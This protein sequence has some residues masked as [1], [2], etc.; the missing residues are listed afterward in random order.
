[1]G[2]KELQNWLLSNDTFKEQLKLVIIDSVANQFC[3]LIREKEDFHHNWNYLLLCASLLAKSETEVGQDAALRIAQHCLQSRHI[4]EHLKDGAIIILDS[5]ANKQAIKLAED[6]SLIKEGIFDRLPPVLKKDWVRHDLENSI[7]LSDQTI[8]YTNR[9][10]KLFWDS[11]LSFKW[12]S[13]SAPTSAGKSFIILQWIIEYLR[14]NSNANIV[15]LVPT[16]ALIQQVEHDFKTL[17]KYNNLSKVSVSTLPVLHSVEN[18]AKI[19]IFTQ[20][21]LH[22]F[23]NSVQHK[24]SVDL[25][26][27]DEAHKV[28]DNHR[29]IL[30]QQAIETVSQYNKEI[31]IL[32]ASPLTNNPHLLLEDAPK[33][34]KKTSLVSED[35]MVNQ[36]LIWV[37]QAKGNPK[38]W[39]VELCLPDAITPIGRFEMDYSPTPESK[40]LPFVAYSLASPEG[41]NLIYANL[42]SDAEKIASQLYDLV[43][44]EPEIKNDDL[45]NLIELTKKVIHKDYLLVRVLQK[46]IGF[47]YGNIP[48]LVRTEIEKLFSKNVIKF[49]VCTSTLVEGVN[50]PCRNI[51]IRGPQKGR[52]NPMN[53]SD[54]WNLA[55]RAGRWGKEFQGNVICIDAR[56]RGVWQPAAPIKRQ[57]YNIQRTCD[58]ILYH[59]VK[60]LINFI[61]RKL[62]LIDSEKLRNLEYVF[63]YLAHSYIQHGNLEETMWA[64]RFP[65]EVVEQLETE[66]S[67]SLNLMKIPNEI[68]LRNPGINPLSINDLLLYFETRPKPLDEL[69][70][71][72]AESDNAIDVYLLI[73]QRLNKHLT[74]AFGNGG[75]VYMLAMLIVNW[76]RGY[77]L[78]RLIASRIKYLENKGRVYRIP[79]VIRDT[80]NDVEQI[81]RFEAPKYLSCYIDVLQYYLKSNNKGDLEESLKNISLKLELGVSQKTQMSLI[82]LGLSRTSTLAVSEFIASDILS[83]AECLKWLQENDWIK[84]DMPKLVKKEIEELLDR[85]SFQKNKI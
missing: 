59:N 65:E 38:K 16:R 51:F 35:I 48:L 84:E 77:P 74:S 24:F 5:L 28:G 32:F 82:G 1:M 33:T 2:F 14:L 67:Q 45:D 68:I 6:R 52:G 10:Q 23:L 29:G 76:M 63:S 22:I 13:V 7:E 12:M 71:V 41:G 64:S 21:R 31:N 57:R 60:E 47:H 46:G 34:I 85:I 18:K 43:K 27:V 50:M 72:P 80:M 15:Y 58:Q 54:F 30:L 42:P 11:V 19:Y 55:G 4:T 83:E 69:F 75:R 81:A 73:L 37:S 8:L 66:V 78:A 20:E 26:V 61:Q 70:P 17:L 9:F 53:S 49:L 39:D 79:N 56:K 3:S 40:R 44:D 25:L 62:E 36:N